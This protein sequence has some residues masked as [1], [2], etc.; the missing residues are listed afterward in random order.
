MPRRSVRAAE[1]HR[2]SWMKRSQYRTTASAG[3][4][5]YSAGKCAYRERFDVPP[6][7]RSRP[8]RSA[9]SRPPGTPLSQYRGCARAAPLRV[10]PRHPP[11]VYGSVEFTSVPHR[12]ES[13]SVI[14]VTAPTGVR[15]RAGVFT[16]SHRDRDVLDRAPRRRRRPV[17]ADAGGRDREQSLRGLRERLDPLL[18]QPPGRRP[19]IGRHR[20]VPDDHR[21]LPLERP[22]HP[23]GMFHRPQFGFIRAEV[24]LDR[25]IW[26]AD[27]PFLGLAGVPR[28]TGPR[29]RRPGEDHPRPRG[30][31]LRA[32]GRGAG[33]K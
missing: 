3:C 26:S 5:E 22:G 21:G 9:R 16:G 18:P 28:R 13:S 12:G 30:A 10:G 15:E 29:A 11:E 4:A 33:G 27:Y 19:L 14:V 25:V 6:A 23:S 2:N 24:G 32:R 20:S 8:S 31:A 7:R 1:D 17:L